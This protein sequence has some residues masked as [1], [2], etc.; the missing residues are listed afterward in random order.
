MDEVSSAM[1]R[2]SQQQ[3]AG[4]SSTTADLA[5]SW[6]D[7]DTAGELNDLAGSFWQEGN[8]TEAEHLYW[9][10][11]RL[12]PSDPTILSNLGNVFWAQRKSTEAIRCYREA[13]RQ[14]PDSVETW[15]NLG[16]ALSDEGFY[17]DAESS[18]R[19]ALALRPGFPEI[20][21]NLGMTLARDG[22]PDEALAEYEEALRLRPDYAE[23]HRNRGMIWLSRGDFTRGWAEYEWRLRCWGTVSNGFRE[24]R[25]RGEDLEGR[26]ILLHAEQ[27]LGDTLQFVRFAPLVK[28]RGGRVSVLCAPA[29]VRLLA[30]CDGVDGVFGCV[31]HLPE[32]DLHAPLMSLPGTLG[33]TLENLPSHVPYLSAPTDL[34]EH[35]RV[36]LTSVAGLRVGIAWQGNPK[37][38]AD[39]RRSVRL[40]LFAGLAEQ[41]GVRL[42]S[43]QRGVGLEQLEGRFPV[44]TLVAEEDAAGDFAETAA[45]MAHLDLVVTADTA[46]A[47]LAGALGVK[48]W[49]LL[50]YVADWR[51]LIDRTDSP[52][53]PTMRLF[54]QELPG[55]WDGVFRKVADALSHDKK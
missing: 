36:P 40:S 19:R 31:A 55:D 1:D 24:P 17:A 14:C 30:S 43:L 11:H 33:I 9:R 34:V 46:V 37:H 23:A 12:N 47:H 32:F 54:R 25:W 13:L 51:W 39:R 6:T 42:I 5:A 52:W 50:P 18:L 21:L 7:A 2:E 8:L 41:A 3:Q 48:V 26:T 49:V 35:W 20:H 45:I 22:R 27:G 15:I 38:Q 53:Y 4:R 28:A 16:V 44:E 10:A 29:L